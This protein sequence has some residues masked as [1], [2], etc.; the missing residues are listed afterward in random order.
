MKKRLCLL[1]AL[2]GL[3][4]SCSTEEEKIV[5]IN[6]FDFTATINENPKNGNTIGFVD[7]STN[8]GDLAF[9]VISQNPEGAFNINSSTGELKV[10]DENIFDFEINPVITGVIKATSE[11]VSKNI[12]VKINLNDIDEITVSVTD[13]STSIDE[14]PENSQLIGTVEAST[15][16]GELTF[17]IL[18][19]NPEGAF[20]V[21]TATGELS[22]LD[23]EEFDY[24]R[25]P[26]ITGIIEV[27][28]GE[29]DEV[30]NVTIDLN[31]LSEP[32]TLENVA[33]IGG[34]G[35]SGDG[36]V[37]V[38]AQ[39]NYPRHMVFDAAGNL[40]FADEKNNVIRKIDANGIIST[41]AGT[42]NAGYSGDGDLAA[43]AELNNPRGVEIDAAGNILIAD[44]GNSTVRK[45]DASG[46][47]T[48][49]AGTGVANFSGDGG[50]AKYAEL[51]S[52]RG[53]HVDIQGNIYIA[54]TNN[55]RVRKIDNN[56]IIITVAG[57]GTDDNRGNG[58]LATDASLR[59]PYDIVTKNN[60]IYIAD[61]TGGDVRK[62]NP[63]GIISTIVNGDGVRIISS[64]T[65]MD[66]DD[67]N[68]LYVTDLGGAIF[69][70]NS[71]EETR[72]I[73][74]DDQLYPGG[75]AFDSNFNLFFS[76]TF[77]SQIK[78]IDKVYLP[79]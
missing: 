74:D 63:S 9:S 32:I 2:A 34:S 59:A 25:N 35:Y 44:S 66:F 77:N 41:I 75:I 71:S 69:I 27:V 51:N 21:D 23:K 45:I 43:L 62:I 53:V 42:G 24:E 4:F 54:D 72:K 65:A 28:N 79:N 11:D 7:G 61:I 10:A 22:V 33:G 73:L 3:V 60:T 40:I 58:N 14:N 26:I 31:D 29:V 56:G 52:P 47:I 13:F 48:T 6:V 1:L 67:N 49:I 37:A 8:S 57:N 30:L 38:D 39:L 55:H 76:D 17:T 15:N 36:S 16:Q 19:Q 12:N 70:I 50:E 64:P 20:A 46:M 68:N 78:K 5:E 18:E